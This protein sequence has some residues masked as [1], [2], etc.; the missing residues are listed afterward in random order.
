MVGLC[1][2]GVAHIYTLVSHDPIIKFTTKCRY[3][4]KRINEKVSKLVILYVSP[5]LMTRLSAV[6]TAAA[7]RTGER[8]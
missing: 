1:L 2:Y 7:G 4:R 3:C 6:S 8:I 5:L